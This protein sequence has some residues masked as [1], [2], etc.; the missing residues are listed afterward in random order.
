MFSL[1]DSLSGRFGLHN[2]CGIRKINKSYSQFHLNSLQDRE[3]P[4]GR[5][6]PW[7]EKN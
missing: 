3:S 4:T 1:D 2:S 6:I 5:I 7:D